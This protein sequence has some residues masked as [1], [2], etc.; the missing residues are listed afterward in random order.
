MTAVI[1]FSRSFR[2]SRPV[3]I[4]RSS[5]RRVTP[6]EIFVTISATAEPRAKDIGRHPLTDAPDTMCRGIVDDKGDR[7]VKLEI[8][9]YRLQNPT[10]YAAWAD[11]KTGG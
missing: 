8:S 10:R 6:I 1:W 9:C 4:Q 5:P 3:R 7:V 11:A 2:S